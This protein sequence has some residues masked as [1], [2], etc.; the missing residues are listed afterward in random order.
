[1]FDA[2]AQLKRSAHDAALGLAIKCAQ[3]SSCVSGD[4][5]NHTKLTS[6]SDGGNHAF[7]RRCVG[8]SA[9]RGEITITVGGLYAFYDHLAI[10]RCAADAGG[11]HQRVYRRPAR[12]PDHTQL[13]L[14]DRTA[15]GAPGEG[16]EGGCAGEPALSSDLF[17][18]VRLEAGDSLWIE[19]RPAS[20]VHRPNKASF[21]GLYRL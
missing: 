8:D 15:G 18:L 9:V 20:A 17:A 21:F 13:L 12:Y 1:L 5:N 6:W 2:A 16:D 3:L 14:E 7:R 4:E 10:C 11:F 19:V